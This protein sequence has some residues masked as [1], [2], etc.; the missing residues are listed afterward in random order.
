[1]PP[2]KS[3]L[4]SMVLSAP[5]STSIPLLTVSR[6]AALTGTP[7]GVAEAHADRRL[8]PIFRVG[9]HRYVNVE[10]LRQR[11]L[12]SDFASSTFGSSNT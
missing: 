2:Q 6:W 11:A 5:E 10:L 1:M 9:K 12:S 4:N 8:I 7:I 3:E